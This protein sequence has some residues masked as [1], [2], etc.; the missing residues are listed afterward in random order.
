MN[1]LKFISV[2][3]LFLSM[4]CTK[5]FAYDVAVKNEDGVTIYYNYINDGKEL[6]VT[7]GYDRYIEKVMIPESVIVDGSTLK[8]TSIR[9]RAFSGCSGLT[10]IAI[11]ASIESIGEDAFSGCSGLKK[12]IVKDIAAWCGISFEYNFYQNKASSNPL[13]YARHLYSD[14]NTEI[15]ELV[16][17]ESVTSIG[18]AAFYGC[19]ALTSITIPASIESIGVSAFYYCYGL[20]KVIVK[21]I[22]AWCDIS[23][24]YNFYQNDTS[25]NP[26]SYAHHLYSDEDT[27]ITELVIPES[28]TSIGNYAFYGCSGLTAITIPASVE[29]IGNDA[30]YGCSGLTAIT[31]PESVTRIG[32]CAFENCSG[33]TFVTIHGN[34]LSIENSAFF[35]CSALYSVTIYKGVTS[36]G[37]SAFSGCVGLMYVTIPEGVE[38]IGSKAFYNCNRLT[39]I[40]IPEGVVS[41]GD[42]AF[43]NCS[44][45]SSVTIPASLTGIGSG[46]FGGCYGLQKVVIKDIAAWCGI[47]FNTNTSNPLYYAGHLYS[48]ENTEITDLIIPEGVSSIGNYAFEYC[49]S[50]TSVTLPEGVSSIGNYAF[51]DCSSLTS[52]TLPEGITSI[53]NNA[54]YYCNSLTS[55]TIPKSVTNIGNGAFYEI[56]DIRDVYSNNPTP[57]AVNASDNIFNENVESDATL[58]VPAGCKD[59][60][61]TA[62]YWRYFANIVECGTTDIDI[63]DAKYTTYVTEYAVDFSGMEGL[64]AYKVTEATMDG[65]KLEEVEQAPKG[66][67]LILHGEEG[68]YTIN[69]VYANYGYIADNLFK[70]GGSMVGDGSTI[71]ALGNKNGNVGFYLVKE[72]VAV[73]ADKGYL[74]IDP[75][76]QPNGIKEFIPFDGFATNIQTVADEKTDADVIYNL[77]GQRVAQPTKS[78]I[79]I[80]NGKK[81]YINK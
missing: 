59:K 13:S 60:Y 5:A 4:V 52:V 66:T 43:Y 62:I 7:S 15:T 50:L 17:P 35:N 64:T 11:P 30:F 41:V 70:A 79:Y 57:P 18:N 40:E 25:S 54:F 53:G 63:T 16:I 75:S 47:S 71:Y 39:S 80:V 44:R 12:V 72:G 34:S 68:T 78:G 51:C 27:E 46:A 6:E 65:V 56:W 33:L 1:K 76:K 2:L 48:D 73:P 67:A 31:I 69:E 74:V 38:S 45:M 3:T 22:A 61:R 24:E 10:A 36:I 32:S 29:S 49:S 81:M 58:H 37:G 28:V 77:A 20:E 23:F 19:S 14:E 21:D 26:L 42:Q 9:N 8:V 55:V